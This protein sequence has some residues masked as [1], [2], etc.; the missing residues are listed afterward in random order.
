MARLP[1]LIEFAKLHNLKIGT[2]VDLIKYRSQHESMVKRIGQKLFKTAWGDFLG[3]LYQDVPNQHLHLA[4]AVGKP[5]PQEITL[6]RVHEPTIILD[7]LDQ[8]ENF[9]SWPLDKALEKIAQ[10]TCGVAVL[11][12][13]DSD[14]SLSH[15]WFK[16]FE[17]KS[18]ENLTSPAIRK[19]DFRTYGIG[20]Q[21]LKDQG[22]GKMR[23][24]NKQGPLSGMAAYQLEVVGYVEAK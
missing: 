7:F 2:I 3:T 4:L 9:H 10:S 23:L 20:A 18:D 22:V 17:S 14:K 13:V 15:H 16:E 5:N 19:H 11:L 1:D 6:V 12:N 8:G 24:M 21:I